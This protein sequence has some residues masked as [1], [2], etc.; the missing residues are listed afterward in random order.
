MLLGYRS[1]GTLY[2]E[3]KVKLGSQEQL[4]Y[5][6]VSVTGMMRALLLQPIEKQSKKPVMDMRNYFRKENLLQSLYS[7]VQVLN[8]RHTSMLLLYKK[9]ENGSP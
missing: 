9:K 6:V 5:L 1:D 4:G 8:T 2:H 3:G 7:K